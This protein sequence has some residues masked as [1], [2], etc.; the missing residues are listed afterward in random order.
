MRDDDDEEGSPS[1]H[2]SGTHIPFPPL[3]PRITQAA[4]RLAL[5]QRSAESDQSRSISDEAERRLASAS[6][7]L[8]AAA[9][10]IRRLQ[11]ALAEASLTQEELAEECRA[12]GAEVE[13]HARDLEAMTR[14]QQAVNGELVRAAY[15]RDE[16]LGAAAQAQAKAS[17]A[18]QLVAA[19]EAE[20][21]DLLCAYQQL[22]AEEKRQVRCG[23]PGGLP[24]GPKRGTR[25]PTPAGRAVRGGR[26]A[27]LLF[28]RLKLD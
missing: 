16:A 5:K 18:E 11:R 22:G 13:A 9:G 25:S 1:R 24:G 23:A 14:E 2:L 4:V 26:G 28:F 15:E 8:S 21:A 20:V 17:R 12:R 27:R 7:D 6:E 10:Q 3:S 19:K